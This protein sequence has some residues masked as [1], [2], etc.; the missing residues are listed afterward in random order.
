MMT[1]KIGEIIRKVLEAIVFKE[2]RREEI[3]VTI[4]IAFDL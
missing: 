1:M 3:R 2:F 4:G